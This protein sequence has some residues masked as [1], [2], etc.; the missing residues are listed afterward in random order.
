MLIQTVSG[1]ESFSQP[2][3]LSCKV[4]VDYARAGNIPMTAIDQAF[5]EARSGVNK[6]GSEFFPASSRNSNHGQW[7]IGR[8]DVPEASL[9][10]IKI[11]TRNTHVSPF[12]SFASVLLRM[13]EEAA[14]R[15]LQ[16][17]FTLHQEANMRCGW[18][19]GNF[20]IIPV[21]WFESLGFKP[22][23]IELDRF[24]ADNASTYYDARI[25]EK[26]RTNWRP[27]K[28]RVVE[29]AKGHTIALP[30]A[31]LRRKIRIPTRG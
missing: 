7:I 29:T 6:I 15:S 23:A 11:N 8:Y 17:H 21:E 26:A 27:E 14:L 5:K 13:R 4:S 24:E 12:P 25:L 9:V 28:F 3:G 30:H 16:V 31:G 22:P 1:H 10:C 18:I 20:D 2:Y 19:E